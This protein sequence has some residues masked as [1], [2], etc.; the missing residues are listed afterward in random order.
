M[1]SDMQEMMDR[2]AKA[3]DIY[4]GKERDTKNFPIMKMPDLPP[5]TKFLLIP[6]SWFDALYSKTGVTG[7]LNLKSRDL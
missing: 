1:N 7:M 5:E 4:Y 6:K 3:N 2:W